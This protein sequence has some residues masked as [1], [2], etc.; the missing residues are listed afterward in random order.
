M[1]S[2]SRFGHYGKKQ[3]ESRLQEIALIRPWRASYV[4]MSAALGLSNTHLCI[5]NTEGVQGCKS[6]HLGWGEQAHCQMRFWRHKK[7]LLVNVIFG[8]HWSLWYILTCWN[9]VAENVTVPASEVFWGQTSSSWSLVCK[10]GFLPA[11]YLS[12]TEVLS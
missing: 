8:W 12:K 11:E 4:C 10:L 7:S 9:Q 3:V 5:I 6:G 2:I 1:W